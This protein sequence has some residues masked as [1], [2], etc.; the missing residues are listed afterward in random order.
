MIL[1]NK[2]SLKLADFAPK[3]EARYILNAIH[4]T[5]TETRVTDGHLLVRVSHPKDANSKTSTFPVVPGFTPNG[6]KSALLATATAKEIA[7]ATPAKEK[8]PILNYA[9]MSL[10]EDGSIQCAVTDLES[11]RVFS[12]KSMAGT[13]P[14]CDGIMPP[15]P[16]RF[17]I[18]L[19]ASLLLKIVKY[20]S[21]FGDERCPAIKL[22]FW[23]EDKPIRID[24]DSD[25]DQ[26]MTA[27]LMP[28]RAGDIRGCCPQAPPAD[29]FA[30]VPDCEIE[31]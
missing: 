3:D 10:S 6:F 5:E 26:G 29:P 23:G 21:D 15:V 16:A 31:D 18:A 28:L 24:C 4:V 12:I 13:F 20:A 30:N 25:R 2:K 22:Q 8:I 17:S 7:K 27:L 1:L 19:D 14:N 11:P 9:A